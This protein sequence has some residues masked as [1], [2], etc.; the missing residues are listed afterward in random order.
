MKFGTKAIHSGQESDPSTGAIMTPI[1]QT[2]TYKQAS[3]GDFKG[4]EYS[5]TGNPTRNALEQNLAALENGK[6][7]L[8]FGSGLGAIDAIIKLLSVVHVVDLRPLLIF[9]RLILDEDD[10]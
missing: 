8:C 2:S 4:Y 6:Y 1:F 10:I 9:S 3:P 7:G 5:R